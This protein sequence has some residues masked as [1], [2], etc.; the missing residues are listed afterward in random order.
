MTTGDVLLAAAL[1]AAGY[2]ASIFTWPWLRK[3]IVGAEAEVDLLH[4]RI[5]KIMDA[6]HGT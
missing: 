2:A 3:A 6:I 4:A 5:A 1:F